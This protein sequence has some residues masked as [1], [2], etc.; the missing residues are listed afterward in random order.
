MLETLIALGITMIILSTL[1]FF[2][3]EIDAVNGQIEKVQNE[4]FKM[5]YVENR[6]AA[7]LPNAISETDEK[8]DFFFF[9]PNANV[10]FAMPGSPSLLFTF[11]NGIRLDKNF[12]NHVIG[13]LYLD[14]QGRLTLATWP[15]PER[16][17]EGVNPPMKKEVLLGQVKMFSLAFFVAPDRPW[18]L[19]KTSAPPAKNK[20]PASV[21]VKPTP[22]GH[23]LP[24][25]SSD[26]QLLPA[27]V[28]LTVTRED[29]TT[30]VFAFPLP[31]TQRQVVYKQ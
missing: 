17:V 13:K 31:N 22:E 10:P 4:S 21:V 25:W 18:Q 19:N 3:R 9:T 20:T 16:W 28:K 30:R 7:I 6:L 24:N 1:T 15:A 27:L 29:G 5:R 11:D 23:W 12:A 2:Y 14:N 26:Y 8:K